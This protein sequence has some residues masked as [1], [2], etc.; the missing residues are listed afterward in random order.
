[1]HPADQ[2]VLDD[3]A[4][5]GWAVMI[6][7]DPEGTFGY[8]IGIHRTFGKP[9]LFI[10]GLTPDDTTAYCNQYGD[11]I[12]SGK[13][14]KERDVISD[15]FEHERQRMVV[16]EV[17]DGWKPF[18]LGKLVDLMEDPNVP[19]L[20]AV[21]SDSEG[22]MPLMPGFDPTLEGKQFFLTEEPEY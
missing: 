6:V 5:Y 2:R 4:K 22:L 13:T 14:Y 1:M 16:V 3:V 10:C 15:W 11:D 12:K 17:H 8:T 9:E 19:V 7:H 20:Q 18:Y 21:W